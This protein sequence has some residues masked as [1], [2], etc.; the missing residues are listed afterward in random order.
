MKPRISSESQS[1]LQ[2]HHSPFLTQRE[3]EIVKYVNMGLKN[4][5]IADIFKI[6][7]RTVE[8]H[9]FH[10]TTRLGVSNKIQLL[11]KCKELKYL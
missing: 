11:N 2:Y 6:S 5:E 1:Q 8:S 3:L 7:V 4:K 10:I 9:I